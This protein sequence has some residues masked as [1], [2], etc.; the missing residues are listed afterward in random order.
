MKVLRIH[1]GETDAVLVGALERAV[2]AFNRSI[3][4]RLRFLS[5]E[6]DERVLEV[7]S[8]EDAATAVDA[9]LAEDHPSV[10]VVLGEGVAA[11]AAAT[12]CAR[13][14]AVLVRIGA[15][16]R[17]GAEADA[18]RAVDRLV[19]VRLAF[20][21]E[22]LAVLESEGLGENAQCIGPA[23]GAEAGERIVEVLSRL[24]RT[25]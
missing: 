4:I 25:T 15:G 20:D 3:D 2:E 17:V 21:E 1:A 14:G 22:D 12:I 5:I 13:T 8:P 16:R 9:A 24:R 7:G 23:D 18:S 11:V 6:I 19:E 10:C